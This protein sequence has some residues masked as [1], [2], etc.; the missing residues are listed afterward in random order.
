MKNLRY[1]C[2]H[3]QAFGQFSL[4][5]QRSSRAEVVTICTSRDAFITTGTGRQRTANAYRGA[6][7]ALGYPESLVPRF[8][9]IPVVQRYV[10]GCRGAVLRDA[11]TKAGRLACDS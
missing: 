6:L 11:N 1:S 4:A 10:K 9:T 8:A 3:Y 2:I 5:A 7:N